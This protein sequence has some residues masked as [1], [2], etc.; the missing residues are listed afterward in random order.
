ME[1]RKKNGLLVWLDLEMTGLDVSK[2]VILE[3]ATI[4]TDGNLTTMIQGPSYAIHQDERHLVGMN[5]WCQKQHAKSGLIEAVRQSTIT[6]SYAQ[7]QTLQ[8]IKKHC[9]RG[10]ALLCGNSIWQDRNFLAAYM[11]QIV[12]YLHYR[13]IDVSSIK[14]MVHYWYPNDRYN[15]VTKS[16]SHRA[17]TDIQESIAELKHYRKYFFV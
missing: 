8:F 5:E 6:V 3:I 14:N 1:D 4:I 16:D 15:S 11:P 2:D 9:E 7:E 13:M 17:L 10:T 12:D